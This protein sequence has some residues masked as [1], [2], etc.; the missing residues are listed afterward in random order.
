[1]EL[2]VQSGGGGC[3][4][5]GVLGWALTPLRDGAWYVTATLK[6]VEDNAFIF[7]GTLFRLEW[8][9]RIFDR[10]TRQIILQVDG[11]WC[12]LDAT[13][14]WSCYEPRFPAI[15]I[16]V[17]KS[18]KGFQYTMST[19]YVGVKGRTY[20]AEVVML[21]DGSI[22]GRPYIHSLIGYNLTHGYAG[23]P[24]VPE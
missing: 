17:G 12:N 11:P 24:R 8:K 13:L 21:V 9:L 15:P 5:L 3:V 20:Y 10:R 14:T 22:I 6:K 18:L 19:S 7:Y 2:V 16:Y 4:G 23:F 1:M